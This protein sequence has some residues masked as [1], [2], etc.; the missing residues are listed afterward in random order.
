M[1]A[2]VIQKCDALDRHTLLN[3]FNLPQHLVASLLSLYIN[4]R[5]GQTRL[6]CMKSEEFDKLFDEGKGVTRQSIIKIWLAER[7][8]GLTP[9]SSFL[10]I[11]SGDYWPNIIRQA[12]VTEPRF[13]PVNTWVRLQI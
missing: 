4:N 2:Y 12:R 11:R 7:L 1:M 9:G 3:M 13:A 5:P 6:H 8:G 10:L